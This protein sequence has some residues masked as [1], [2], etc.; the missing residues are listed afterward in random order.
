[1]SLLSANIWLVAGGQVIEEHTCDVSRIQGAL[2]SS[3]QGENHSQMHFFV[4]KL[5]RQQIRKQFSFRFSKLNVSFLF[6]KCPVICIYGHNMM[7]LYMGIIWHD[8]SNSFYILSTVMVAGFV[9]LC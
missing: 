8:I 6:K 7:L 1:M 4:S 9:S 3:F 5:T 2:C